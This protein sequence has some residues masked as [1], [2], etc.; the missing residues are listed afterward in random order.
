MSR[1]TLVIL[2]LA[3][4]ALSLRPVAPIERAA[5]WLSVPMRLVS[6]L[7]VPLNLSRP[8][9]AGSEDVQALAQSARQLLQREQASVVPTDPALVQERNLIHAQIVDRSAAGED[10]LIVRHATAAPVQVGLPVVAG[11]AYVGRVIEVGRP[12]TQLLPGEARIELI[13]REDARV[14]ARTQSAVLILGGLCSQSLA[15]GHTRQL[16]VHAQQ[17]E[18]VPGEAVR[19]GERADPMSGAAVL[20]NGYTIGTLVP[21]PHGGREAWSVAPLIDYRGGLGQ[22]LILAPQSATNAAN[23]LVHDPLERAGWFAARLALAST[24]C[25]WRET[26][27]LH[28]GT[29]QGLSSGACVAARGHYLGRLLQTEWLV[30]DLRLLEDPGSSVL[31]LADFGSDESP[32]HLG[33]LHTRSFDRATG[34]LELEWQAGVEARRQVA[35]RKNR[36]VELYTGSGDRWVP[37]GL[38]IGSTELSASRAEQLLVITRPAWVA[39]TIEVDVWRPQPQEPGS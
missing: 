1:N 11:T 32:L 34:R 13:T 15:G 6:A 8:A 10:R 28:A 23:L 7:A 14:E 9:Q 29:R 20:A 2:W 33:L 4:L 37:A 27:R 16:A 31:V 21:R 24:P 17:G 19:V 39:S 12:G 25:F 36:R 38:R 30:S 18:L 26:R 22:V 5:Q 35:L 3:L